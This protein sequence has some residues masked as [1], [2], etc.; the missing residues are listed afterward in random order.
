MTKITGTVGNCD[1]NTGNKSWAIIRLR[2]VEKENA[3]ESNQR[4]FAQANCL[5]IQNINLKQSCRISGKE[6]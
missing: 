4:A 6:I 2:Q 5:N 1:W 3:F